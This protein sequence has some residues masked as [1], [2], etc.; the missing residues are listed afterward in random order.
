MTSNL[1][2]AIPEVVP[3]TELSAEKR[4]VVDKIV[5]DLKKQDSA[6]LIYFGTEGQENLINV[7]SQLISEFSGDA[8]EKSQMIAEIHKQVSDLNVGL[9][10]RKKLTG[11]MGWL[12]RFGEFMRPDDDSPIDTKAITDQIHG[13][14]DL[15]DQKNGDLLKRNIRYDDMLDALKDNVL[16][17]TDYIIALEKYLEELNQERQEIL[18]EKD[19]TVRALRLREVEHLIGRIEKKRQMFQVSRMTSLQDMIQ[20]RTIQQNNET[21]TDNLHTLKV[22]VLPILWTQ[23]LVKTG[24]KETADGLKLIDSVNASTAAL[25]QSNMEETR[26]LSVRLGNPDMAKALSAENLQEMNRQVVEMVRQSK[27]S[28]GKAYEDLEKAKGVLQEGEK[29]IMEAL[30][31]SEGK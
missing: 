6:T 12:E 5:T 15:I 23:F 17:V 25:M 9:A 14:R 27:D 28:V 3:Y 18:K 11:V 26:A 8:E 19:E 2:L 16:S 30:K 1:S 7:A 22:G 21:L 31:L 20:I 13:I 10:P 29:M 24:M 4:M